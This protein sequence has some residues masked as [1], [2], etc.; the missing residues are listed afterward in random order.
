MTS[1]KFCS[2]LGFHGFV[3]LWFK[4]AMSTEVFDGQSSRHI[5]VGALLIIFGIADG[6]TAF[7]GRKIYCL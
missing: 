3:L 2:V 1:L 6:G 4:M 5:V 7:L